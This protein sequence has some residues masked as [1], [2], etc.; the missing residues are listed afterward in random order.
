MS[1]LAQGIAKF[2]GGTTERWEKISNF[3]GTRTPKEIIAK[4]KET[5]T[6]REKNISFV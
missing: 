6:S 3:I 4:T 1:L 5:S 2:P